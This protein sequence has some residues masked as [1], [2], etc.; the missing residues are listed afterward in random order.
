MA[1]K[2][3]SPPPPPVVVYTT[4]GF[5]RA[6]LENMKVKLLSDYG[7]DAAK[8]H[9]AETRLLQ[10]SESLTAMAMKLQ[11]GRDLGALA[12]TFVAFCEV[13]KKKHDAAKKFAE[14]YLACFVE[15]T[16]SLLPHP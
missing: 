11:D 5:I 12:G 6:K 15:S 10:K 9:T 2:E 14:S 4:E 1:P 13:P 8:L 7:A 3:K 16:W